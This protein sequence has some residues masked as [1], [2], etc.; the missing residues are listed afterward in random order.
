MFTHLSL[1]LI[2]CIQRKTSNE[3]TPCSSHLAIIANIVH[4]GEKV[5]CPP[6]ALKCAQISSKPDHGS[7]TSL[8]QLAN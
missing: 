5:C 6:N 3:S 2:H 8:C 4:V 7:S 1:L